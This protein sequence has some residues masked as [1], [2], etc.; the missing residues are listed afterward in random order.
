M[1]V[2]PAPPALGVN[3]N[4]AFTAVLFATRSPA[5]MLNVTFETAPPIAP[6]DTAGL[7]AVGSAVVC[8]VTESVAALAAPSVQPASVT[9]TAVPAAKAVPA[10]VNAMD[11]APGGPGVMEVPC[12]DT[13]ALG[14]GEVAKK[15]DG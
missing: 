14:V 5:A 7:E 12:D 2:G 10:T 8:T 4:V 9:V 3:V 13:L 1:D 11:V 6:Q 15:P